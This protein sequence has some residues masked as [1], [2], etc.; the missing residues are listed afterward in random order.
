MR[1]FHV[2]RIVV[3]IAAICFGARGQA[4]PAQAP[5]AKEAPV[6]VKG[7]PPRAAPGDYQAHAQAGP[8]TIGA[9]FTGHA[10]NPPQGSALTSEDYVTVEVALFGPAGA[11]ATLSSGDFSLRINGKKTALPSQPFGVV[12]TSLKDPE[13]EPPVPVEKKSKTS[14]GGGG[15]GEDP[16]APPPT[17]PKPPFGFVR[18]MQQRVQ[19][20]ALPEGDRPLPQAGL[21]FF[22]Y[23]RGDK[24]IHSLE[25][26]YEGPAGKATLKLTP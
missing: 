1:L 13:W 19:K 17:P 5:P 9:E 7:M 15:G 18:A 4:P 2:L 21:I 10:I 26:I 22:D 25:L 11:R 3:P 24:S 14:M 8:V 23:R 20:A 12:L 16:N 6:E